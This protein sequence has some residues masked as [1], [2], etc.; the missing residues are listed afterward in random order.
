MNYGTEVNIKSNKIPLF[1]KITL[2]M[3]LIWVWFG[4][5]EEIRT[6]EAQGHPR[7]FHFFFVSRHLSTTRTRYLEVFK[8]RFEGV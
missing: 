8:R 5:E 4:A 6:L 2:I 3:T 1:R 7:F